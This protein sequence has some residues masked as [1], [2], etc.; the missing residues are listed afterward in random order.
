MGMDGFI[1]VI[2]S[3]LA[4]PTDHDSA[5]ERAGGKTIASQCPTEAMDAQLQKRAEL[6][7]QK[8]LD[9]MDKG[10]LKRYHLERQLKGF[11]GAQTDKRPSSMG[12][13]VPGKQSG[14]VTTGDEGEGSGAGLHKGAVRGVGSG[15]REKRRADS[16]GSEG[17]KSDVVSEGSAALRAA[18]K[19]AGEDKIAAARERA[20]QRKL[21]RS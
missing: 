14:L 20:K 5:E 16:P 6:A 4:A 1:G 15:A 8:R 3:A 21:M 11:A 18:R 2:Q 17:V 7:L 10:D 19:L 12:S 13:N 9:A